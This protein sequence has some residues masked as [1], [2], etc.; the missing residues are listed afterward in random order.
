MSKTKVSVVWLKRDLRLHDHAP[1]SKAIEVGHP[2]ILLYCFEPSLLRHS[3]YSQRHWQFIYQSIQ[4]L[5]QQLRSLGGS[6]L[7]I[8]L[9]VIDFLNLLKDMVDIKGLYSHQET[10][11]RTT[12]E[13]DKAVAKWCKQKEIPWQ[14]FP[15]FGVQRGRKN[16]KGWSDEWHRQMLAK[17]V[18]PN[19]KKAKFFSPLPI[20]SSWPS[21]LDNPSDEF[22]PGGELQGKT[23][24][25]SFLKERGKNYSKHISKPLESCE[26]C[27]RLSAH[28]AWGNLSLRFVFQAYLKAKEQST[29]K[30]PLSAFAT[31]L[32]WHCHF[33]QKFEMEDSME[34]ENLNRGFDKIEKPLNIKFLEA[35]KT[36]TT[37]Y[38]LV[39][40]CMRCVNQTGYLN[41]RMRA[42]VVSFLTHHLWQPWQAGAHHLAQQFL[43]FE[44]GIHYPQFQMQA[45]MTGINTLRVYNPVKQSH[46]H[47][48]EGIFIK[49]WVPELKN[50]PTP[51]I[52]EPW[53]IP[54]IEQQFLGME[55]GK[56][57]PI[58]IVDITI[59]GKY[60][61]TTMWAA[62]KTPEVR[63]ESIRILK[64]HT[65]PG[66]KR[67]Q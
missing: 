23:L 61:R 15:Q 48:P 47:D 9:E 64:K 21:F 62:F 30:R 1:L 22:Q 7:S 13:R 24:L 12:F 26:S 17:Q 43:D 19:L 54:P 45:G 60:A 59:T 46:D 52:H 27:S 66:R 16:R 67:M 33:I 58:P 35:W 56:D 65:L 38:P 11:V 50:I 51:Y 55:L 36:G 2:I 63:N 4:Q 57:Y 28:L 42:M 32:R 40:A 18:N 25:Q 37:G 44:P 34:F 3:D 5:N 31:R 10:G 49:Q 8:Q 41:F 6:V 20:E 53:K 39:D 29:Y 14:E